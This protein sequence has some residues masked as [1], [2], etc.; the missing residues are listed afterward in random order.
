MKYLPD[1]GAHEKTVTIFGWYTEVKYGLISN[2]L[3]I[4]F[5]DYKWAYSMVT[6]RVAGLH[7]SSD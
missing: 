3:N 5:D 1:Q 2:F 4:S 6:S 7:I